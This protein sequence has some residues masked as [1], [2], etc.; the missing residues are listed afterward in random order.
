MAIVLG[1]GALT[2]LKINP[3]QELIPEDQSEHAKA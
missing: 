3:E 1:L 2:W